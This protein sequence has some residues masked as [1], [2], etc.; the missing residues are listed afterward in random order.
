MI[1]PGASSL[2][3]HRWSIFPGGSRFTSETLTVMHG[4]SGRIYSGRAGLAYARAYGA[5]K[6]PRTLAIRSTWASHG[7][8]TELHYTLGE[9]RLI[10]L[11]GG[12]WLDGRSRG[13]VDGGFGAVWSPPSGPGLIS[14]SNRD[15]RRPFGPAPA[16]SGI[17]PGTHSLAAPGLAGGRLLLPRGTRH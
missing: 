1:L 12:D 14:V 11:T 5:T 7:F 4:S 9:F 3:G 8:A 6:L 10:S 13:D 17:P 15:G 16:E 2:C